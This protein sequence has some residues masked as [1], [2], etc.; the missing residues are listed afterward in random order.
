EIAVPAHR[1]S[2]EVTEMSKIP[3]TDVV[4]QNFD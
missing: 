2:I 4:Q 1:L 3:T